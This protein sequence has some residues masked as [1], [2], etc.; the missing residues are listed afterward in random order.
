MNRL[1]IITCSIGLFLF[2]TPNF[3]NEE[4]LELDTIEPLGSSRYATRHE[5]HRIKHKLIRRINESSEGLG[6][7]FAHELERLRQAIAEEATVRAEADDE[8]NNLVLRGV[9]DR[10]VLRVLLFNLRDEIEQ[11]TTSVTETQSA[12]QAANTTIAQQGELIEF[13]QNSSRLNTVLLLQQNA[14]IQA[15]GQQIDVILPVLENLEADTAL[16]G[17]LSDRVE[18]NQGNIVEQDGTI[19]E[20]AQRID[21]IDVPELDFSAINP[22]FENL[23]NSISLIGELA[24]SVNTNKNNIETQ[25]L[26]VTAIN[27]RLSRIE[28]PGLDFSRINPRLQGLENA[29]IS[30][31]ASLSELDLAVNANQ[32]GLVSQGES[33]SNIQD[34]LAIIQVPG[35]DF[36]SINPRLTSVESSIAAKSDELNTLATTVSSNKTNLETQAEGIASLDTRIDAIES[37]GVD[38]TQ[39]NPRFNGLEGSL[40]ANNER[41]TQ[42][43]ASIVANQNALNSTAQGLAILGQRINGIAVPGLDFAAINPRLDTLENQTTQIGSTANNNANQLANQ[44]TSINSLFD[45]IAAIEIPDIDFSAV[46]ARIDDIESN[47]VL[48]LDGYLSLQ[49]D[50]KGI[51]T[52]L[53]RGINIQ[54]ISSGLSTEQIDGTGNLI[55]GFNEADPFAIASCSETTIRS[56]LDCVEQGYQWEEPSR[57][58]SHNLILGQGNQYQYFG[59]IIRNNQRIDI[60]AN[61]ETGF[62]DREDTVINHLGKDSEKNSHTKR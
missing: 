50:E 22:R 58:G 18:T 7:D 49:L 14:Q 44:Q 6:E 43:S 26:K 20:L 1:F 23:E 2:A 10:N 24:T 61:P 16:I 35:L 19:N 41:L 9:A 52:A 33:I 56:E 48:D 42:L 60:L 57:S 4:S 40:E 25:G 51:A 62:S 27:N 30:I 8:I 53:F 5:L 31:N 34:R 28:V 46:N 36:A 17:E 12:L 45:Q 3:S 38:F 59:E 13:V 11:L 32:S 39:I 15:L 29:D 55:I 21:R 54:L 37:V 47:S